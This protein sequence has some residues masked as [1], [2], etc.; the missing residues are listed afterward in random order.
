MFKGFHAAVDLEV[1]F[2]LIQH[3]ISEAFTD[4][5]IRV[6]Q[7]CGKRPS[8]PVRQMLDLV[9]RGGRRGAKAF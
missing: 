3:F 9:H 4:I 7:A 1:V 5:N 2:F 6:I 8:K